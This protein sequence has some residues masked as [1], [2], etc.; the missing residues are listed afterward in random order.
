[1]DIIIQQTSPLAN[2]C[3]LVLALYLG[4]SLPSAFLIVTTRKRS[5]LRLLW[6]P[7]L[8][9][10]TY[11]FC[12]VSSSLTTSAVLNGAFIV[13][14]MITALQC[15]HLLLITNVDV[16]EDLL[17]Q[18][19]YYKPLASSNSLYVRVLYAF[20][21]LVNFR[22]INTRW[23]VKDLPS[24]PRFYYA[25]QSKR[26]E[27]EDGREQRLTKGWYIL[28]QSAIIAWQHLLLDV[29]SMLS[30]NVS[31]EENARVFGPGT[32][33]KYWDATSEQWIGRISIGLISWF[34][35]WRVSIDIL[36]RILSLITVVIVGLAPVESCPPSFGSMWDAYTIRR[37]WR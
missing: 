2:K 24:F 17:T 5:P 3:A 15:F 12:L 30:L 31:A 6:I 27:R 18:T 21:L 36:S 33:S 23:Q 9:F 34:V 11:Q 13:L 10:F 1:M 35:P 7:G 22:G 19:I 26:E 29:L 37:F 4:Y 32:E 20:G 28:R 14:G 8:V 16:E 25:S